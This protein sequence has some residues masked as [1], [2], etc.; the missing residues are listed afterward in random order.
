[1][2]VPQ[3]AGSGGLT[4]SDPRHIFMK[5]DFQIMTRYVV[6]RILL[7]IVSV[8]VIC[9]ITFFAMNAIPGGPFNS[10]KALSEATKAVLM[11]RYNLD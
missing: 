1:M 10:E 6:K 9:A 11:E 7:A 8:L 4:G 5:G 2:K 3:S